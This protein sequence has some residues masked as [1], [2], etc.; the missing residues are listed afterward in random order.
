[1]HAR[2][3]EL[4][5]VFTFTLKPEMVVQCTQPTEILMWLKKN[6]KRRQILHPGAYRY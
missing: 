5:R 1:M 2:I 6:R 4:G 3:V